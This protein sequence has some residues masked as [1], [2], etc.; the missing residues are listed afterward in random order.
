ML[1]A[2]SIAS[3]PFKNRTSL[4][5]QQVETNS[6]LVGVENFFPPILE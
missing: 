5:A 6:Y 4:Y 3:P 1:I 2:V